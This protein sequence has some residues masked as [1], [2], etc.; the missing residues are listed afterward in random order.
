MIEDTPGASRPTLPLGACGVNRISTSRVIG[1]WLLCSAGPG[2]ESSYK[3]SRDLN[4][5]QIWY[6]IGEKSSKIVPL[7]APFSH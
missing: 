7:G 6:E 1:M 2:S 3:F 5:W 4:V